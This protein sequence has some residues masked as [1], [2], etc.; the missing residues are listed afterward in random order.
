MLLVQL[1]AKLNPASEN[2][3]NDT[4]NSFDA[5]SVEADSEIQLFIAGLRGL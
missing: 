4:I 2:G 5:I 3:E 1:D